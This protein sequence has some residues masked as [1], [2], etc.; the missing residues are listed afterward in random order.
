M[1]DRPRAVRPGDELDEAALKRFLLD[2]IPDV[3]E[4]IEIRQFPSGASNLTYLVTAGARELVLRRPPL[5]R[6]AK[7]AHD[8]S[9][10]TRVMAA[11][12]DVYPYVPRVVAFCDDER[13]LGCDFYLMERMRGIILRREIPHGLTLTREETRRLC[14]NVLDR[15]ID[16]HS[17]DYRSAGLGDFGKPEGYVERQIE[18]WIGRY[19][20]ARTP[21]APSYERVMEWL[22]ANMPGE[23]RHSLIHG[24]FRFDNVVL[25]R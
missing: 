12:Q 5:G 1:I 18:G 2:A 21:N 8:M 3:E 25:D 4:P 16:L 24:D 19:L 20:E 9:R 22:R 11:L 10:E 17:L 13:V 23:V 15:L 14:T 6:K 7:S